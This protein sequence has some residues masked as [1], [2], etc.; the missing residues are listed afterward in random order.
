[1]RNFFFYTRKSLRC[2]PIAKMEKKW[3]ER[4]NEHMTFQEA[5][6]NAYP[7][8]VFFNETYTHIETP[9]LIIKDLAWVR[10]DMYTYTLIFRIHSAGT[11]IHIW[12][13]R[14]ETDALRVVIKANDYTNAI[15]VMLQSVWNLLSDICGKAAKTRNSILTDGTVDPNK[16]LKIATALMSDKPYVRTAHGSLQREGATVAYE[17]E[18]PI[19]TD[20]YKLPD[21]IVFT[22]EGSLTSFEYDKV[23]NT[24]ISILSENTAMNMAPLHRIPDLINK[25][26][27]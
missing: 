5:L 21:G 26:K 23:L 10:D 2:K 18:L 27:E 8:L 9:F 13:P 20:T 14:K 19:N 25:I 15:E 3:K 7:E 1:M 22:A 17:Q 6:K 11:L 16:M 4:K 12:H 24:I